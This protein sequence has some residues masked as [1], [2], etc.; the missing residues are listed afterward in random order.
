MFLVGLSHFLLVGPPF[1]LASMKCCF[2]SSNGQI[3]YI[4]LLSP[5]FMLAYL[6]FVTVPLLPRTPFTGPTPM[7]SAV[8]GPWVVPDAKKVTYLTDV[9]GQPGHMGTVPERWHHVTTVVGCWI[10]WMGNERGFSLDIYIYMH[11]FTPS[12]IE[13]YT[14]DIN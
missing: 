7:S 5:N 13:W 8:N 2:F 12:Y 1:L 10:C 11:F 9:E 3:M 6:A 14:M 4:V